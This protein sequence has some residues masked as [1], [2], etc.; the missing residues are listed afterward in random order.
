MNALKRWLKRGLASIGIEVR[1]ISRP[2]AGMP[3]TIRGS[4]REA[5]TH[6]AGLGYAPAWVID[7]GAADGTPALDVFSGSRLVCIDPLRENEQA[8]QARTAQRRGKTIIAGAGRAAG[9]LPLHVGADRDGSSFLEGAGREEIRP[10]PIVRLDDVA[11]ELEIQG[12]V[13]LKINAQGMELDVLEGAHELLA[14]CE[15]VIIETPLFRFRTGFPDFHDIVAFMKSLGYAVY[16]LVDGR[17][18]PYDNAL[19]HRYVVFAKENGR[20][21]AS[22]QWA[23]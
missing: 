21:R 17:N 5:L 1:R 4:M 15:I 14:C 12:E 19:A 7:V 6:L 16:D 9:I 10:V 11:A 3:T 2:R 20:F 22:H 8:L 13:L 23:G 18:R